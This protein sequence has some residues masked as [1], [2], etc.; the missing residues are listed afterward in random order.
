MRELGLT[1]INGSIGESQTMAI[2]LN[3]FW[4]LKR[5]PD[6]DGADF[7]VQSGH[8]SLRELR[9]SNSQ[10]KIFGIVQSKYFEGKNS[11]KIH[12]QYVLDGEDPREEFFCIFH[13]KDKDGN[14]VHYF[15]KATDVFESMR[16]SK[17]GKFFVFKLT[18]NRSYEEYKNIKTSVI[19]N[20]IEK[21]MTSVAAEKNKEYINRL[22]NI[23]ITPTQHHYDTPD[24]TYHLRIVDGVR[25]PI[26]INNM[27]NH[28]HLLEMRRDLY[29]NQG[30]YFWG[31]KGAGSKFLAVSILAHHFNGDPPSSDQVASLIENLISKIG[32][33]DELKINTQDIVD[34]LSKN[35]NTLSV[36]EELSKEYLPPIKG[37]EREFL[38]VEDKVGNIL[39]LKCKLGNEVKVEIDNKN[40]LSQIDIFLPGKR[41]DLSVPKTSLRIGA[42]FDRSETGEIERIYN[43]G[44]VFYD[45]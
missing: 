13:S 14:G 11:V 45:N 41:K 30:D 4:V 36:V 8:Q 29:I 10:I 5:T 24:F 21:G 2:L 16:S 22:F 26:C 37:C 18:K 23:I 33:S 28:K 15:F 42:I 17:C 25:V 27:N 1:E 32:P 7:L 43:L 34:A 44:P 39:T 31:N 19:L 40:L 20:E 9:D 3:K 6:V 12:K 38:E 35:I